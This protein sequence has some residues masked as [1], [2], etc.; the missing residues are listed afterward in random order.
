MS[1]FSKIKALLPQLS[2]SEAKLAN[3]VLDNAQQIRTLSSIELAQAAG[4][5]QSSVIKFSQKLGYKGFPTFKLA[6]VDDLNLQSL[7]QLNKSEYKAASSDD[8]VIDL[9]TKLIQHQQTVMEETL[10]LNQSDDF[11]QV[12][13]KIKSARK[14][15]ITGIGSS[16]IVANDFAL[17]LQKIGLPA[18]SQV[19]EISASAYLATMQKDDFFIAISTSGDSK[20]IVKLAE[21]AQKNGCAVVSISKYGNNA[22]VENSDF[23]LHTAFEKEP[24]EHAGVLTRTASTLITDI[25]FLG[26]TQ[27]H[28]RWQKRATLANEN[29]KVLRHN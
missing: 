3:F 24:V 27:S 10:Q 8:P 15:L 22:L 21:Q 11:N 12:I 13:A 28:S 29:M 6:I 25:L 26:L 5:S 20:S 14:I 18:L 17:K 23:T 16:N 7:K 4:V 2:N 9:A 1:S 19:D